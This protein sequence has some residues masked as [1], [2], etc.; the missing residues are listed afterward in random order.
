[1]QGNSRPGDDIADALRRLRGVWGVTL[2]TVVACACYVL[3]ALGAEEWDPMRFVLLGSYFAE[4]DPDGEWGYD[5]QYS[6]QI[7]LDPLEGWRYT[8]NAA[9]RYQRVLYPLLARWVAL[10]QPGWIPYTLILVNLASIG[11]CAYTAGRILVR[12]GVSAWYALPCGLYAG[13]LIALR[14]DTNEPLSYALILLGVWFYVQERSWLG[15]A[16]LMLAVF[17]KETALL[18]VGAFLA[19]YVMGKKWRQAGHLL[20]VNGVPFVAYRLLLYHWF[21][22]VGLASGGAATTSFSLIPFGGLVP[23]GSDDVNLLLGRLLIMGPLAVIP[24][25]AAVILGGRELWRRRWHPL[26]FMLLGNA[27]LM[28]VLPYSTYRELS[29]TTRLSI[30]LVHSMVL[31]GGWRR[32]GRVLNYSLLWIL[33]LALLAFFI[34]I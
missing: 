16:M 5:G 17:A 2:I 3:V 8:D 23:P 14:L 28:I 4:G 25:I 30:G 13:L 34:R 29:G 21:G 31:Y 12:Y 20:L 7:A 10:G 33:A 18:A 15:A 19:T 22:S 32:G 26:A 9:Y 6:Y 24:S 27:L 11:L 1:M